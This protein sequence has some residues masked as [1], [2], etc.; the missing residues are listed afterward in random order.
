MEDQSYNIIICCMIK[1][2]TQNNLI[3][4]ENILDVCNLF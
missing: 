4:L 3:I 1:I 2:C